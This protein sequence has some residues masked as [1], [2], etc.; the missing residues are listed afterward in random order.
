MWPRH[1]F[2][3][4][5]RI[6]PTVFINSKGYDRRISSKQD[7]RSYSRP[8]SLSCT[9]TSFALPPGTFL[10]SSHHPLS[11]SL[12]FHLDSILKKK[13][14]KFHKTPLYFIPDTWSS[15]AVSVRVHLSTCLW[16]LMYRTETRQKRVRRTCPCVSSHKDTGVSLWDDKLLW[17]SLT[18][19]AVMT[20]RPWVSL[21]LSVCGPIW[22]VVLADEMQRPLSFTVVPLGFMQKI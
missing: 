22:L 2:N 9:P 17:S 6:P 12:F 11:T 1:A 18:L 16:N 7:S 4:S 8:P 21:F 5:C 3:H 13:S 20:P 10:V 14:I 19:C 15:V